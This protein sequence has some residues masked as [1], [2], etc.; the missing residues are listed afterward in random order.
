MA[1]EELA[2]GNLKHGSWQQVG[3]HWKFLDHFLCGFVEPL[4]VAAACR[5]Y[6]QEVEALNDHTRAMSIFSRE[7]ELPGIFTK[8]LEAPVWQQILPDHLKE[9]R[10]YLERH[11]ELDSR[12]EG[13][14]DL[15]K[16]CEITEDVRA[17]Y[18]ARLKLYL[19]ALP[20]LKS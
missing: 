12:E 20:D 11:V 2:T 17:F 19:E 15:V 4:S 8:I 10:F 9:F 7:Q 6:R 5:V 13:H 18:E 1:A 3:D 14:G 16:H